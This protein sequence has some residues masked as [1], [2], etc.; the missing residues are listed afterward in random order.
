MLAALVA[1][2]LVAAVVAE[3]AAELVAAPLDLV[4]AGRGE[5]HGGVPATR[6]STSTCSWWWR[7]RRPQLAAVAKRWSPIAAVGRARPGALVELAAELVA[8]TPT[9]HVS[10]P[11]RSLRVECSEQHPMPALRPRTGW[12]RKG[13]DSGSAAWEVEDPGNNRATT[14]RSVV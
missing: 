5:R 10:G 13:L 4:R 11:T 6:G 9:R 7:C 12:P 3:L 2:A 1:I 14:D 8:M